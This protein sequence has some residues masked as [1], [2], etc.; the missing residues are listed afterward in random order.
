MTLASELAA[1]DEDSD[2][3]TGVG[4]LTLVSGLT[5]FDEDLQ[6]ALSWLVELNRLSDHFVNGEFAQVVL[7]DGGFRALLTLCVETLPAILDD[8]NFIALDVLQAELEKDYPEG[9]IE[10]PRFQSRYPILGQLKDLEA[11]LNSLGWQ[12][13][14]HGVFALFRDWRQLLDLRAGGD[15]NDNISIAV[16]VAR[17]Q[18][19][20]FWTHNTLERAYGFLIDGVA[21]NLLYVAGIQ[22]EQASD[23]AGEDVV[24]LQDFTGFDPTVQANTTRHTGVPIANFFGLPVQA[25]I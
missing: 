22:G 15:R 6:L 16:L 2:P 7:A 23:E 14:L 17:I 4:Q 24:S 13:Q 1:F 19:E 3:E 5:A 9:S 10:D 12:N 8:I 11:L 20:I 18:E 25:S 21:E